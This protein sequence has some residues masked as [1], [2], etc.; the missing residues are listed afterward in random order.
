M[1]RV[2]CDYCPM[3]EQHPTWERAIL[4]FTLHGCEKVRANGGF[5]GV[6]IQEWSRDAG[7]VDR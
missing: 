2:N 1:Y 4:A 5:V 7:R 3:D 6:H